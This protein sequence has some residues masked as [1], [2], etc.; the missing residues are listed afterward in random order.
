[1]RTF[2]G[3]DH[4]WKFQGCNSCSGFSDILDDENELLDSEDSGAAEPNY[5]CFLTCQVSC[6]SLR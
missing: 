4:Y 2:D 1:M 6:P 3:W 5:I